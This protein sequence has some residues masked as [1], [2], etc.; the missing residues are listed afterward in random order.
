[1][2]AIAPILLAILITYATGLYYNSRIQGVT[3]DCF[4][5]TNQLTEILVYLAGVWTIGVTHP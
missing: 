1:V 5:A 2:H 4:G 3:G